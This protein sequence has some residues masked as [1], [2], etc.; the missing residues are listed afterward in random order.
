VRYY[1]EHLETVLNAV[2]IYDPKSAAS[3]QIA[4]DALKNAELETNL[5]YTSAQF[6][7]LPSAIFSWRQATAILLCIS[8]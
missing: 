2:N 5:S 6:A 8:R 7:H 1:T 4:Q 3:I